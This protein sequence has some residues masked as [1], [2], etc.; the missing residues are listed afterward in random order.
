MPYLTQLANVARRTGCPVTEVPGWKGRG[1]GPQ[2]EVEGIVCHHTAGPAAGGDYPSL[3]VVRDGR[4]GLDGP[5]SQFGLGR[6]GRIYVIAAGRCWHNAPSTSPHHRND[7]SLG[8]EAENDGKQPWPAVQLDAYKKLVAELCREYGLPASRVKGHKEVNTQKPDPHGIDM[9]DFR[10]AVAVLI[11]GGHPPKP[12]PGKAPA[13]PGRLLQYPPTMTGADVYAW[14]V[15]MRDRGW[16]LIPD[17]AYGPDSADVC[18]R[19]QVDCTEHGWPL[20]ADRIVGPST[21]RAAWER[22][23]S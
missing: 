15:Q 1:H 3:A 7:T 9:G 12:K 17:G 16:D 14:Q 8:I 10:T 2:P 19:F 21:W 6:S 5:L 23:P 13:F 22:P 4:P 20:D 18:R 11:R